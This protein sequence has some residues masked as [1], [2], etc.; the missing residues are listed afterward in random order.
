L[1]VI[2][3]DRPQMHQLFL[4]LLTNALKFQS[5]DHHPEITV[6]STARAEKG[7]VEIQVEDNGIGFKDSE[8]ERIFR[9][10]ERINSRNEYEGSGIG[11]AI[12]KRIVT[13]HGGRIA[14]HSTPGKGSIFSVTLPV[15]QE[16]K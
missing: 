11:L 7:F 15:R 8:S 9:P 3:G 12:C 13:R 10:F 14:V 1:P 16:S 2:F 5:K 6:R 4:N